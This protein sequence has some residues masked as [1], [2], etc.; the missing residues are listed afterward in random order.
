MDPNTS[1]G[2]F[3]LGENNKGSLDEVKLC[4]EY[5]EKNEEK[6]VKRELLVSLKGVFYFVKFIINPGEDDVEPSV[7]LGR[8]FIGLAKGIVDFGNRILTIY[9]DTTIFMMIQA[10]IGKTYLLIH[11]KLLDVV[12]LDKLKLDGELELKEVEL[13]AKLVLHPLADTGSNINVMPYRIFSKLGRDNVKPVDEGISM[14]DHSTAK[15]MGI[16]KDVLCQVGVTTIL[17]KFLIIDIPVDRDVLIVV[18][19][20]ESDSD[21]EEDYC[22][23]RDK[24]GKPFHGP[25]C[26]SYLNYDDPIDHALALQEA[27]NLFKKICVW[28]KAIAF[29]GSLL[30]P[31]QYQEW[32]PSHLGNIAKEEDDEKWHTKMRIMDTYGNTY[33]QGY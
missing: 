26:E 6:L 18:R 9:P 32:R 28:K 5:E 14:L 3:C 22:L 10:M 17:A 8:S 30:V 2:R 21:D 15:P 24:M 13:E 1:I 25:N 20:R 19:R 11:K 33:E 31:L 16:L 29:L 7:I 4:L 23:K 27:L 12:L